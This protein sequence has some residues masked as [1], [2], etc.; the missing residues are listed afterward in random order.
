MEILSS[1]RLIKNIWSSFWTSSQSP[2]NRKFAGLEAYAQYFDLV[3]EN[4]ANVLVKLVGTVSHLKYYQDRL[5][6][7]NINSICDLSTWASIP[8]GMS[9]GQSRSKFVWQCVPWSSDSIY[10]RFWI[11]CDIKYKVFELQSTGICV[12]VLY[13]SIS[14]SLNN[15]RQKHCQQIPSPGTAG[16]C[17]G[18]SLCT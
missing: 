8:F 18:A 15:S 3:S 5:N 10:G 14:L 12:R 13:L 2:S 4:P 9:L 16:S 1:T 17:Y 7:N 6:I 11:P